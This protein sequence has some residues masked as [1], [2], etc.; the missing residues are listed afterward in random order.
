MINN[1]CAKYSH[2]VHEGQAVLYDKNIDLLYF[3]NMEN[4]DFDS[5]LPAY[6]KKARAALGWTQDQLADA[7]GC[8]KSNI[9]GWENGRH[10]PTYKQLRIISKLSLVPLPHDQAND[11]I[12]ILGGIKANEL[13]VDQI[14]IIRSA[15]KVPKESRQ[16]VRKIVRT[17]TESETEKDK[18]V[19]GD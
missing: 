12:E 3:V 14:E 11:F 17:F 10:I 2:T 19:N 13:D 5:E 16:Q 18:K 8:T 4:D 7:L 1:T 9:S 6:I 15:A